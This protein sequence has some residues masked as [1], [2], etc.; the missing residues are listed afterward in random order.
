VS[1]TLKLIREPI[2]MEWHRGSFE[3]LVDGRLA[4]SVERHQTAET[5]VEP[6][7]HTVQLKLRTGRYSSRPHSFEAADRRFAGRHPA[8]LLSGLITCGTCG[9]RYIGAAA[10]GKA[11]RYRYYMCWTRNRYGPTHCD[12]ERIRADELEAAVFDALI[13]LYADPEVIARAAGAQHQALAAQGR[14]RQG[15]LRTIDTEL[16]KTETAVE[17]YMAAFEAG[18]LPD[19]VFGDRVRELGAKA[20]TLT[21]R[22]AELAH[23]ETLGVGALPTGADIA[24]VAEHLRQVAHDAPD[25]IRK[26]VAQA[27]V[28]GLRVEQ[29][30]QVKPTF[31]ILPA[32][33]PP[34]PG[35]DNNPEHG[36]GV[37]AMTDPVGRRGLEPLTP[38]ASCKCATRLRQRPL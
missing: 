35:P 4:G 24:A 15:E 23:T 19:D 37:R 16:R 36:R 2:V 26:A 21:A 3:I 12:A 34:A 28:Q 6:G 7:Q 8:Y 13:A 22:K 30:R 33:P 31:R 9:H 11:Q 10:T 27:F 1:A 29:P 20:K 14:Q 18:T 17:R 5:T 25:D 32:L 38:C